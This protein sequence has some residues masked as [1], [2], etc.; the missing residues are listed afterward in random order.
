M[1]RAVALAGL[2]LAD[3]AVGAGLATAARAG[4]SAVILAYPRLGP[5]RPISTVTLEQ[6]EA[7]LSELKSGPYTVMKLADIVE[8]L[9]QGAELPDRAVALTFDSGLRSVYRDAWPR[10]R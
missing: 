10:L 7:H 8:A 6:F 3:L 1:H 4:D 5:G 9:R 2:L